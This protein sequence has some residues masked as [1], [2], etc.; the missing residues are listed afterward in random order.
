MCWT[1]AMRPFSSR[2][3]ELVAAFPVDPF[4]RPAYPTITGIGTF[5]DK[6][7]SSLSFPFHKRWPLN[8]IEW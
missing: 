2:A 6:E 3:A 1:N 4:A 5:P 7:L 8:Q